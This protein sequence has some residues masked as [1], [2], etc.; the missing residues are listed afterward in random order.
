[1]VPQA[2][3]SQ[4]VFWNLDASC[5]NTID[6]SPQKNEEY[7]EAQ[8]QHT[9]GE[10]NGWRNGSIASNGM[11]TGSIATRTGSFSNASGAAS[12]NPHTGKKNSFNLTFRPKD[13][14]PTAAGAIY[15]EEANIQPVH[16][17]RHAEEMCP[18]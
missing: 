13:L 5:Q 12:T 9:L 11:G 1:M 8:Y 18:S 4:A 16:A 15:I 17:P 3:K 10:P 6:N 7:N 14:E 2:A